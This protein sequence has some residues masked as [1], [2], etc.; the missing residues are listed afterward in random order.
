MAKDRHQD[1]PRPERPTAPE[2]A[3]VVTP[4][5]EEGIVLGEGKALGAKPFM[6][7]ADVPGMP[8]VAPAPT[9]AA[10][11]EDG[12]HSSPAGEGSGPAPEGPS[13]NE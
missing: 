6:A 3:E 4:P 5:S 10:P 7:V 12:G 9:N 2:N 13:S 11:S 8:D 1:S